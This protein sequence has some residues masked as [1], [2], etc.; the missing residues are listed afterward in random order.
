MLDDLRNYIIWLFEI[1]KALQNCFYY[2]CSFETTNNV[3][4]TFYL[5]VYAIIF[6]Y[7][8]GNS[9]GANPA[10]HF[11]LHSTINN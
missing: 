1:T 8:I 6:K 10:I 5:P 7:S 11:E 9:H 2:R 3:T 4:A